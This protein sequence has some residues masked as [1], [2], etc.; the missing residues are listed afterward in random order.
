MRNHFAC[1]EI[2][3][4]DS[5][6]F[7]SLITQMIRRIFS[8]KLWL[9]F[10]ASLLISISSY[11]VWSSKIFQNSKLSLLVTSTNDLSSIIETQLIS[12]SYERVPESS[13]E[14]T[15]NP[16]VKVQILAYKR[17]GSSFIGEIFN[18]N[19]HAWY[20]FEPLAYFMSQ[21]M[22]KRVRYF[23]D[24]M[25]NENYSS[26]A[27]KYKFYISYLAQL[28]NCKFSQELVEFYLAA[29]GE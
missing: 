15:H 18:R 3:L 1:L 16:Q 22:S 6:H 11:S 5:A 9:L 24:E 23:W 4:I 12:N 8:R 10:S 2:R 20:S 19:D 27:Y 29:S 7:L 13:T 14:S 17:G 26:L 25:E 28:L 21:V